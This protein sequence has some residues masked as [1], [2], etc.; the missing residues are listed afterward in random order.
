MVDT[1]DVV[2]Y[3][4]TGESWTVAC[5]HDEY[6]HPCGHPDKTVLLKDCELLVKAT[7]EDRMHLLMK[8][9][10]VGGSG[11]RPKCARARLDGMPKV[12]ESGA[13]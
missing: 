3:K 2:L 5:V 13:C 11:H 9:A 6:V 8:L 10:E 1:G 12:Y 7:D 4:R